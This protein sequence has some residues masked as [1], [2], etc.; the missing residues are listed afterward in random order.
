MAKYFYSPTKQKILLLLMAGITLGLSR[1]PN[2]SFRVLKSLPKEW[3]EIHRAAL[4]RAT[5]EFYQHR[6]VSFKEMPNGACEL[7]LTE[8]GKKRA[9]YYKIDEL[10]IPQPKT[11]DK[12]WR[13]VIFDIP[14]KKRK[15]RDVLRMKLKGLGFYEFQKSV[16]IFPFDCKD[17]VDFIIEYFEIRKYIRYLVVES[18]TNEAELKLKFKT[19]LGI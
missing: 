12:K 1:S 4:Y 15:A 8:L 16:W 2:Q 6:L 9:L 17:I 5:K 3:K 10:K 11:W 18:L 13:I 19:L 14:E 7:V